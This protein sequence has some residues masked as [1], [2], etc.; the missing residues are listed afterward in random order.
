MNDPLL[1]GAWG[2]HRSGDLAE[3]A[4]LYGAILSRDARHFDALYGLGVL[5][6]QRGELADAERILR[7]AAERNP[8]VADPWFTLGCALHRLDR[9]NEAIDAFD[10]AIALKPGYAQALVN[11]GGVLMT[12]RRPAE[13]LEQFDMAIKANPSMA[14][15]WNNRGNALSELGRLQEA[16]ESYGRVVQLRPD[17][18]EASVNRGTALIALKRYD[19]ALASYDEAVRVQPRIAAAHGGRANALVHMKRYEEAARSYAA[20]VEIEPEY[21]YARGNLAYCHLHTCEWGS[22][23]QERTQIAAALRAGK[24][25]VNPFQNFALS[26]SE[27]EQR[28]AAELWMADRYP[29]SER[30]TWVGLP[31]RHEKIRIAYISADFNEHAVSTLLAGVFEHHDKNRF[32]TIAISLSASDGSP[33]RTRLIRAFDHFIDAEHK[34][35]AE[36]AALLRGLEADIAVDLMGFTGECRPG[37]LASRPA[38]VQVNYLGFPGTMGA[39]H[40][41]YILADRTVIPEESRRHYTET[42]AY[43]P[44]SY[45]PNDATRAICNHVPSRAKAGLP[46][47]GFVFASF[48]NSYKF[49]PEVFDVWMR[50]LSAVEG[51]V[52]WLAEPNSAATGNLKREADGRGISPERLV[53]AP[54]A[55]SAEDHL[56]RLKL[57]DLFLDTLPYNAHATACDALWAGLPVLT[58][59]GSTFAGRVGASLLNAAGMP[60]LIARELGE[61]ETTAL[62]L[63][64]NARALAALKTKLVNQRGSHPLFDTALFTRNLETVFRNMWLRH[65][66]G[67]P[68]GP[69]LETR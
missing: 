61:Y 60:E 58:C 44:Y 68:A 40:I 32:E 37:I 16:V 38:P 30:G 33:M 39:L 36:T 62:K 24:H 69:L 34:T 53:F 20:A 9:S 12:M 27:A 54:F 51:S 46:E 2:A 57:A 63:A 1:Q 7:R 14:E 52:L 65:Q 55:S 64:R 8:A 15:A 49:T 29:A 45:L 26:W 3:A 56:V 67:L 23:S 6:L 48:N 66:Q 18:A 35:D 22:L 19:A 31:Y 28:R 13:A 43:L 10:R 17:V 4:R 41:D 5:H 47:T 59:Q 21:D 42:V 50:L 11:K 25:V